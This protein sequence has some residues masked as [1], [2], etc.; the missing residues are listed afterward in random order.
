M[1]SCEARARCF[2]TELWTLRTLSIL[3]TTFPLFSRS[4]HSL[5]VHRETLLGES[6][7]ASRL[8]YLVS[9]G[10]RGEYRVPILTRKALSFIRLVPRLHYTLDEATI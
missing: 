1:A 5:L 3:P 8:G 4:T 10:A 2:M 9:E 7:A 6:R